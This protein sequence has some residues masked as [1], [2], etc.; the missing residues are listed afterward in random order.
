MHKFNFRIKNKKALGLRGQYLRGNSS[1]RDGGIRVTLGLCRGVFPFGNVTA[2]QKAEHGPN[3][4]LDK[5][6]LREKREREVKAHKLQPIREQRENIKSLVVRII[7]PRGDKA[8]RGAHKADG[9]ADYR[10][11]EKSGMGLARVE[12]LCR[13]LERA[14]TS[15][16]HL[17]RIGQNELNRNDRPYWHREPEH[18]DAAHGANRPEDTRLSCERH[19]G[20]SVYNVQTVKHIGVDRHD[21]GQKREHHSLELIIRHEYTSS[22]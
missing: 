20:S 21:N 9:R 8:H 1:G 16:K 6:Q 3:K 4:R 15:H 14:R 2:E 7:K 22:F 19:K 13:K 17:K 12:H 11:L 5:E 18:A 10:G